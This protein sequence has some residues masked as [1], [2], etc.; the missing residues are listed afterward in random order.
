MEDAHNIWIIEFEYLNL[1]V[2]IWIFEFEY[3]NLNIWIWIF[4]F[5]YLNLNVWIWIFEYFKGILTSPFK[6]MEDAHSPPRL[7][8]IGTLSNRFPNISKYFKIFARHQIF[9]KNFWLHD[10]DSI[11]KGFQIFQ[12]ISPTSNI[13]NY[14]PDTRW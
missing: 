5:E 12:N 3:L 10:R 11:K 14:L 6:V 1:N 2:W 4:E 7:R 9:P 8:V 13:S